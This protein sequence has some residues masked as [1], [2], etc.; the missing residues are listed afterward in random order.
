M[1]PISDSQERN[2]LSIS[3]AKLKSESNMVGGFYDNIIPTSNILMDASVIGKLEQVIKRTN[4]MAGG[5]NNNSD[6][7][8]TDTDS[9]S[10]SEE[11]P[12]ISLSFGPKSGG[13]KKN[14]SVRVD[15]VEQKKYP[16]KKSINKKS[17]RSCNDNDNDNNSDIF[18]L[19]G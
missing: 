18:T 4:F 19:T 5:I 9:D 13:A 10:D 7:F 15:I 6:I 16:I 8:D 17:R 1:D 3:S 12:S 14:K 2:S 11:Y